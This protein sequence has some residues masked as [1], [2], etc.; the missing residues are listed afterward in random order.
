MRGLAAS[1]MRPIVRMRAH[2][3]QSLKVDMSNR[4]I[5]TKKMTN[6][7]PQGFSQSLKQQFKEISGAKKTSLASSYAQTWI[8]AEGKGKVWG[9]TVVI[10][11][12]GLEE[13]VSFFWDIEN[14]ANETMNGKSESR[15]VEKK[16]E[17]EMTVE[18]REEVRAQDT[19]SQS[20]LNSTN[21]LLLLLCSSWKAHTMSFIT[22]EN[23]YPQ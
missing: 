1:N 22:T 12:A 9:K 21:I 15:I 6:L 16:G 13:T 2:F 4:E 18:K 19:S 14:R 3:D 5:L 8:K 20:N 11:R 10:V 17:F 23:S 7:V